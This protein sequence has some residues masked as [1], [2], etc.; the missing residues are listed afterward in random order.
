MYFCVQHVSKWTLLSLPLNL[1][2][3][4]AVHAA[5]FV[6]TH[7]IKWSKAVNKVLLVRKHLK[8]HFE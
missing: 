6:A 8:D 1:V 3:V 7:L 4:P 2:S 5:H